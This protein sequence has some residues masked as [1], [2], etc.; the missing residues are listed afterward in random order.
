MTAYIIRRLALV[1]LTVIGI[2]FLTFSAIRL[3]PGSFAQQLITT[4][5]YQGV[6]SRAELNHRL[7]LDQPLVTQ[8]LKWSGN[9]L[10]GDLG[11]SLV[12]G[13]SVSSDIAQ[14]LPVT[15]ELGLLSIVVMIAVGLPVG[16]ISAIRRESPLDYLLRS[17]SIGLL[18]IPSYWIAT[19]VILY[20]ALWF[21]YTPPL[22]YSHLSDNPWRN[23]QQMWMPA[24]I[25]GVSGSAALMR[26][27]RTAMLEVLNNDYV[28]TA[29]AKGMAGR[30]VIG[31]HALRNAL[32]P[33][34]TLVGL[35]M[36]VIVGGS[37][38]FEQI[39]SLPGLGVYLLSAVNARD[40]PQIEA[41]VLL[42]ATAVVLAN[43]LTDLAYCAIDP[44]IRY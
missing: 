26:F 13:R 39:F 31:R 3:M 38:I 27:A 10:R 29:R 6:K 22:T 5:G 20:L 28:R 42:I 16:V 14:R 2:S 43:F 7:G 35:Q 33:V 34:I 37:V 44:R 17:L 12:S 24:L 41:A 32:I 30:V 40:Y 9:I 1:L 25:L 4:T 19:L 21:S 15:L 8:Y 23:L 18:S 36:G 11:H